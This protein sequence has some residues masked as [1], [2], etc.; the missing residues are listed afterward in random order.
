MLFTSAAIGNEG[1][2]K[3][4]CLVPCT[5]PAHPELAEVAL[6]LYTSGTTGNPKGVMLTY[7][8]I[9]SNVSDILDYFHLQQDDRM[10]I[11]RPLTNASA[12]TGELL[13]ALTTGCAIYLKPAQQA[14][15]AAIRLMDK[16]FITI[17]CTTPTVAVR[18]I[19]FLKR[20]GNASLRLLVLSGEMLYSEQAAKLIDAYGDVQIWNAYGLT[21]ASPRIS[22]LT[23]LPSSDAANCV[24]VPLANVKVKIIDQCGNEVQDG[25]AGELVVSGP[26]IMRGYYCDPELTRE[27]IRAGWLY[28][29]DRAMMRDGKLYI[30]GRKDEMLIRSGT[31]VYPNEIEAQLLQ[32]PSVMEALVVGR[33]QEGTGLKIHALVVAETNTEPSEILKYLIEIGTEPRLMPD[34]IECRQSLPK[35]PSGKLQRYMTDHQREG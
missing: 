24:G 28:T 30:L 9:W 4:E 2:I 22:C 12:I 35:T 21:E 32:H 31:N 23:E 3:R 14:P 18:F 7:Q 8:N 13:P 6:I 16:L 10:F 19:P 1:V 20:R 25:Q 27:K 17:L 29:A 26:N 34:S 11:I 15:L 33:E 5:L